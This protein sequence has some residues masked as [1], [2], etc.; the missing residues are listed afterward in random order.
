MSYYFRKSFLPAALSTCL[1]VAC[2][3]NDATSNMDIPMDVENPSATLTAEIN[4]RPD[5]IVIDYTFTNTADTNLVA[6]G[7]PIQRESTDQGV[8]LYT[9]FFP[10]S[11]DTIAIPQIDGVLA[12]PEQAITQSSEVTY[13]I[14]LYSD[15][16]LEP[17]EDIVVSPS[18]VLF[19]V[20]FGQADELME[21]MSGNG[22]FPVDISEDL[23]EFICVRLAIPE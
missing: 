12:I 9:G 17:V 2:D 4:R 20:A 13:P 1:L 23:Q 11:G 14:V 7:G 21:L 16:S 3:S 22:Q 8:R 15:P 5:R 6:L 10:V 18:E 19:C